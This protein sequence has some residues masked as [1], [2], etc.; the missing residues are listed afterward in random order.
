MAK[1][2]E[3]DVL[4]GIFTIG[5]GLYLADGKI[6]KAKLNKVRTQIDPKIFATGKVKH[7]LVKDLMRCKPGKPPDF[8][9]VNIEMR[10]KAESTSMAY[11]GEYAIL[12][13]SSKDI[14][15]IDKKIDQLIT[16]MHGSNFTQRIKSAVD[17]FLDNNVGEIVTFNVIADGIAG[18]STGGAVKGDV[19]LEVYATRKGSTKKIISG[20]LP[21]SIKSESVTVANLSPY[22][23]MLAIA[24]S[25]NIKWDAEIKYARLTKPFKGDTEQAAKFKMIE[26]LYQDLKNEI[27]KKAAANPLQF[28]KNAMEFFSISVFGIDLA[29]VIDI[30]QSGIKEITVEYFE[31]LK[32]NVVLTVEE[33]GLNLVFIDIKTNSPIFQIRTKLR[34]PPANEAKFYL[35]AGKGVYV[36]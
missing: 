13:K 2:N 24:N 34:P 28:T 20:A 11:G 19:T 7:E 23:G 3:G 4:E 26:S 30:K 32:K 12:Y 14:G 29:D 27:K 36:K 9:N 25:M 17:Y 15:N 35:E 33:R 22:K 10:L 8:F 1:L 21:F 18:E 6:D 16:H 31:K 5:I